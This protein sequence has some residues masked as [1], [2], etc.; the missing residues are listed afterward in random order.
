MYDCIVVGAGPAGALSAYLLADKGLRTLLLEKSTL[1]RYK[2]CGGGLP[3]KTICSIP[4]DIQSVLEVEAKGGRI[5]Y[6]GRT[7][8]EVVFEKSY[9]WLTMRDRFDHFLAQRAAAAGAELI[10][11]ANLVALHQEDHHV[12]VETTKGRFTAQTL[13]GADGVNSLT[14]RTLGL[15]PNRLTGAALE[16]EVEVPQSALEAQGPY[17]TFDFG[18]LPG[19]YGWVFPK[20]DHLSVGVFQAHPGKAADIRTRL[21]QYMARVSLLNERKVLH[22]QGHLIPLGSSFGRLHKGH[23]LLAGDAANLADP[24]IGEG[25]YYALQSARIASEVITD[26]FASGQMNLNDY[27]RR[28]GREIGR[29]LAAARWFAK[30]TYWKPR[31][32]TLLLSRSRRVQ[33]LLFAAIRGDIT[34]LQFGRRF[35]PQL[36]FFVGEALSSS[37]N[38]K[39]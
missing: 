8:L 17:V 32:S 1:P 18:A 24:W 38:W 26:A 29:E 7:T 19:G 4:F 3:Y 28:I 6:Q 10:T 15:L 27:S 14:A 35:W 11:G 23:V 20:S 31:G 33:R 16:A 25:I 39:Q 21:E 2:T 9:G 13:V 37:K 34:M 30:L 12:T 22:L 5:A 36:P